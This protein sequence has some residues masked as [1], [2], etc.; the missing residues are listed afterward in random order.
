MYQNCTYI[1]NSTRYT[2]VYTSTIYPVISTHVEEVL[3]TVLLEKVLRRSSTGTNMFY[4][5]CTR[6]AV[7]IVL[8]SRNSTR[9]TYD[10]LTRNKILRKTINHLRI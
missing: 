10:I 2:Y 6:D 3:L 4:V 5:E 7:Q 1:Q 9:Y 8:S